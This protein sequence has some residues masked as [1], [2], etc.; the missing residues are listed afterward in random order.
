MDQ[1]PD[2]EKELTG[3]ETRKSDN[4]KMQKMNYMMMTIDDLEKE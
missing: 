2:E 1:K 3:K 4:I